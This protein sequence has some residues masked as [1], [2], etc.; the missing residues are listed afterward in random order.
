MAEQQQAT[1]THVDVEKVHSGGRA[2]ERGVGTMDHAAVVDSGGVHARSNAAPA[3][4]H[5]PEAAR[6]E[7]KCSC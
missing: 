4:V 7:E 1:N 2:Q 3:V 6:K 5:S